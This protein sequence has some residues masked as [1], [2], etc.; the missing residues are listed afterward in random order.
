MID[1]SYKEGKKYTRYF[2]AAGAKP[3]KSQSA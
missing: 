1:L 3:S 2:Y